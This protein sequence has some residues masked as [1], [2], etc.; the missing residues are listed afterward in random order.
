MANEPRERL[1]RHLL[2]RVAMVRRELTGDG[3]GL[4]DAQARLGD[5]LDSMGLV[6][7]LLVVA[8]D[9]GTTPEAIEACVGRQFGTVAGLAAAMHAAGLSAGHGPPALDLSQLTT[10]P[11]ATAVA[12]PSAC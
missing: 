5:L 12:R 6:E 7:F 10:V 8:S 4:D 9:C 1:T 11:E 2:D 3:P